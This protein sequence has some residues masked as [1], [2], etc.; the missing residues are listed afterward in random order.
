MEKQMYTNQV[1]GSRNDQEA[2]WAGGF[3]KEYIER[4]Q[5]D[6]RRRMPFWKSIANET[7]AGSFVEF[8][9]NAGWNLLAI[10][11]VFMDGDYPYPLGIGGIDIN[12]DAVNRAMNAGIDARCGGI[13]L[14]EQYQSVADVVFT[15]GV[16]IHVAPEHLD[17][18]MRALINASRRYVLAIEYY[19]P[20]EEKLEY[21]GNK[22]ALWKRPYGDLYMSTGMLDMLEYGEL[23]E[24]DGFDNCVYWLMERK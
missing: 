13:E 16:L 2:L 17:R 7:F 21:R 10:K 5:V 23:S 15:S 9:C 24:K 22:E 12:Q 18:T 11:E 19:A 8:G 6:W 14:V 3:G 4:N 20:D 1:N